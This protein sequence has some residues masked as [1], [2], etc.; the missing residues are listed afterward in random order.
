MHADNPICVP[1]PLRKSTDIVGKVLWSAR[2]H[3]DDDGPIRSPVIDERTMREELAMI[4]SL[5]RGLNRRE[6]DRLLDAARHLPADE[7]LQV[8]LDASHA[9]LASMKE[10]QPA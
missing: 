6:R 9:V 3:G 10:A 4:V 8:G 7:L 2:E 5:M 1:E